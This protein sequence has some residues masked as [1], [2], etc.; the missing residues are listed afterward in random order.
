MAALMQRIVFPAC[1]RIH[2]GTLSVFVTRKYGQHKAYSAQIDAHR[3]HNAT[4]HEYVK[5]WEEATKVIGQ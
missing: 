3:E 1:R 2:R 4:E 5:A